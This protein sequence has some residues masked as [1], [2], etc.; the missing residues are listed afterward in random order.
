MTLLFCI[1]LTGCSKGLSKDY[2]SDM[3]DFCQFDMNTIATM[4]SDN[5]NN[6]INRRFIKIWDKQG[7]LQ[8]IKVNNN[9]PRHEYD[10]SNLIYGDNFRYYG[11]NGVASSIVGVDVSKHQG[12]INWSKVAATGIQYAMVRIGYR[13]YGNGAIVLDE[14]YNANMTGATTNGMDVGVYFYSQAINYDE[15]VEEA[16]FVLS[17]L[18]N[19]N[20]TYPIV[21]DTEDAND[22]EA[23]TYNISAEDRGQALRGFC[24]TIKAA[25]YQP[26]VYSNKNWL[27]L[28]MDIEDVKDYP[29]WYAQYS[30]VPDFPYNF[31]MWQYTSDAQVDGISTGADLNICFTN[32]KNQ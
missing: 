26:M 32:Y 15:G 27:V 24:D 18:G 17:N 10:W 20:V 16:N 11:S 6:F 21:Y 13:G 12:N 23:R 2:S 7:E 30:E 29:L 5:Y 1:M 3:R 14:Y 8:Y 28:D 19:Y 4:S 31:T 9:V 22:T 25:G